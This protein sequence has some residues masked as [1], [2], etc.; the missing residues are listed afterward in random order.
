MAAVVMGVETVTL[1]LG[2]G[3]SIVHMKRQI[4]GTYTDN[5]TQELVWESTD[6]GLR[7]QTI[8][9]HGFFHYHVKDWRVL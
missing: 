7:I 5:W 9:Q 3:P 6:P 1:P 4:Q 8:A 2:M